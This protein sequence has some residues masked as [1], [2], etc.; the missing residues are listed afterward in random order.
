MRSWIRRVASTARGRRRVEQEL[1]ELRL[2]V[3]HVG[4]AV[5]RLESKLDDDTH[6]RLDDAW[7]AAQLRHE[8][9]VRLI[10]SLHDDDST[11]GQLQHARLAEL[12]GALA[13]DAAAAAQVRHEHL[14]D[15][16]QPARAELMRLRAEVYADLGR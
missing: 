10:G 2:A 9:L 16:L 3:E 12:V 5:V 15:L 1:R 13:A 7:R 4:V 6:Q 11:A 14:L 8:H